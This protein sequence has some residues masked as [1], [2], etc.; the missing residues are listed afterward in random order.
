MQAMAKTR[1]PLDPTEQRIIDNLQRFMKEVP[2]SQNQIADMSGIPQTNLGRYAR[3][4][5]PPPASTLEALAA[6]FGRSISDF[7]SLNPPPPPPLENATPVFFRS[8]PGLDLTREDQQ[9]IQDAIAKIHARH[10]KKSAALK[11]K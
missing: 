11:K 10:A 7:Y 8:R 2:Y 5:S 9:D 1:E 6:V 3:G 4:E